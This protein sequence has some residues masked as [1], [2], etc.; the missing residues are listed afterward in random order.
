MIIPIPAESLNSTEP[1]IVKSYLNEFDLQTG[2]WHNVYDDQYYCCS[3]YKRLGTGYQ[4]NSIAYYVYGTKNTADI[5]QLVLNINEMNESTLA[6]DELVNAS[7]LLVKKSVGITLPDSFIKA[8]YNDKNMF[9]TE[10]NYSITLKRETGPTSKY[11]LTFTIQGQTNSLPIEHQ[12]EKD[13][14]IDTLFRKYGESDLVKVA[15]AASRNSAWNDIITA[16]ENMPPDSPKKT[17]G[18]L[19]LTLAFLEQGK[20]ARASQVL[21]SFTSD[22]AFYVLLEGRLAFIQGKDRH[23]LDKFDEALTRPSNFRNTQLVRNDA[24]YYTAVTYDNRYNATLSPEA[25]QQAMKAWDTL[26]KVYMSQP[27]HPRFK[28]ANQKLASF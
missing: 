24:L 19:L 22:D 28:L 23:A 8:L 27:D 25:R 26:I 14:I 2:T 12:S 3:D 6:H 17:K 18:N 7:K 1:N 11:S 4:L 10:K 16:I 13:N 15:D 20:A 21:E 9:L 5:L